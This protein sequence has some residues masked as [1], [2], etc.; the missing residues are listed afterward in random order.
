[1]GQERSGA[2]GSIGHGAADE[3]TLSC[4]SHGP[5]SCQSLDCAVWESRMQRQ[6]ARP[7]WRGLG[8]NVHLQR[9]NAP[10]FHPML[11]IYWKPG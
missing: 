2:C 9:G 1:M 8:G 4:L 7:V 6:V 10:P 5:S 11:R 3:A